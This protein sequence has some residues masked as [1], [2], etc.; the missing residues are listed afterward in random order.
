MM[1]AREQTIGHMNVRVSV[2][3][4]FMFSGGSRSK[5][6]VSPLFNDRLAPVSDGALALRAQLFV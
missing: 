5:H 2:Y 1:E 3:K 6:S 4:S